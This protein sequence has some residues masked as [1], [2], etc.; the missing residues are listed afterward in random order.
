MDEDHRPILVDA[1]ASQSSH[2]VTELPVDVFHELRFVGVRRVVR[3]NAACWP[4]LPL[5]AG[6]GLLHWDNHRFLLPPRRD[7][8]PKIDFVH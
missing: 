4:Y 7:Q 3:D 8:L 5:L 1:L 2:Y 6:L